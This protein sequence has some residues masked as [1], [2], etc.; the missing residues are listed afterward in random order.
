LALQAA[1]SIFETFINV[2][3]AKDLRARLEALEQASQ[4][5]RKAR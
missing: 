1:A 2:T 3:N 5:S 4:P